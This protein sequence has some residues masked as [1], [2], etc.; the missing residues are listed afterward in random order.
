[1]EWLTKI[2]NEKGYTQETLA[3]VVRCSQSALT[4]IE[5]GRRNPSVKLAKKIVHVLNF[6]WTRFFENKK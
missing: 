3:H 2:R 1:M 5:K 4:N 6:D